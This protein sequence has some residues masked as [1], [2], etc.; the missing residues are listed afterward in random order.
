MVAEQ[1]HRAVG[2]PVE[3]GAGLGFGDLLRVLAHFQLQ[4]MP[5]ADRD[6]D[7]GED[8]AQF[9]GKGLAAPGIGAVEFDVDHRFAAALVGAKRLDRG[10]HSVGAAFDADHRVK[11]AEDGQLVTGNRVGDR[12]DQER[13]VVVDDRD[14]HPAAAGFAAERL[15]GQRDLA[16]SAPGTDLGEE[17]GGVLFR[18][19][20][21]I[22][23]F[24]GK[25]I[26]GQCFANQLD[27]RRRQ[28]RVNGHEML[29][30]RGTRA[31]ACPYRPAPLGRTSLDRRGH[32]PRA[33]PAATLGL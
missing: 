14:A 22:V 8:R 24:P 25:R 16:R 13:H 28:A 6:P 5:V 32:R 12:I 21:E 30:L 1:G 15:D 3:Q 10:Q 11:Q 29:M 4:L 19:L 23:G 31:M 33:V 20:A 26:S 17:F 2:E 27:Q 18:R 9:G 7:I